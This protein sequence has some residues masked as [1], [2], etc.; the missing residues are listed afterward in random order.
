MRRWTV[1]ALLAA[2]G[3]A[4]ASAMAEAQTDAASSSSRGPIRRVG[5]LLTQIQRAR[6]RVQ[7]NLAA[8]G[9]V[10]VSSDNPDFARSVPDALAVAPDMRVESPRPRLQTGPAL[11]DPAARGGPVR[12]TPATTI[13]SS[14]CSGASPPSTRRT[15]GRR[16]G[17]ASARSW[18]SSTKAWTR[19][20]PISRRTCAP[21]SARRLP[22]TATAVSRTGSRS[23]ASTSITARTSPAS[24][25]PPTTRSASSAWRRRPRSWPWPCSRAASGTATIRGF[26]TASATPPTTAPTSST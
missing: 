9:L 25:P 5:D 8:M 7:R 14:T 16:G 20:I 23:R 6:G 2:L 21:T 10:V 1:V 12:P 3:V 24:S 22:R 26:S 19:R 11:A 13:P 15:G 18:P 17:S 4:G